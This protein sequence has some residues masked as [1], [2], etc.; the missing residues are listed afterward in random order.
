MFRNGSAG[1]LTLALAV[2][3]CG[4]KVVRTAAPAPD[5]ADVSALWVEPAVEEKDLFHG[6]AGPDLAPDA[7]HTYAL[8]KVDQTGYSKGYELRGPDGSLWSAKLGPEVQPEIASSR[9]LWAIGY[10]QPPTYFLDGWRL[11]GGT[12]A[13][14]PPARFRLEHPDWKAAGDWSWYENPF[15]STRPFRG[16]IVANL[17]LNNWD[18]KS[19]NN[20]VYDVASG[21]PA[22]LYVVRD[23]GAS[24]GRMSSPWFMRMMRFRGGQGT[25]ND[26]AG[27]ESQGFIKSVK[28]SD[29]EFHYKGIYPE[30]VDRVT[31]E[32]VLWT[33]RLL[34][35]L[36]DQQWEDAFRA[37]GYPAEHGQRYVRKLKAK[38]AEG[39]ALSESP[40]SG[41]GAG[42]QGERDARSGA[43]R[44]STAP[45]T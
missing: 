15:A 32:D 20:R 44:R 40:S 11:S 35:R 27:F 36:S 42:S 38:I 23:L 45:S 34:A 17:L 6:P 4:G 13:G 31:A 22:R 33:C 8:V 28:G 25:R 24:L 14:Q 18:W 43:H 41:S 5:A 19:S 21:S 37:T 26:I 10:H 2:W 12:A 16:L 30:I 3:A 9:I 1:L 7:A 39:L 29:V